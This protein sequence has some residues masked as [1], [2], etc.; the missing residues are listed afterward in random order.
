MKSLADGLPREIAEQIHPDW[1][2]NEAAY[3]AMREQLVARYQGQWIGF[4]DGAVVASGR[5]PVVVF[6]AAHQAAEHPFFVCVGREDEPCRI[7]R[8]TF[9]Y[10]TNYPGEALPVIEV[11]FRQAS[12]LPG[13]VLDRVV[14]DTGLRLSNADANLRLR[15]DQQVCRRSAKAA[16][17]SWA[18]TLFV[19]FVDRTVFAPDTGEAG[20]DERRVQA[21]IPPQVMARGSA[22]ARCN[23]PMLKPVG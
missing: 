11:E 12:G 21:I 10:D 9:A 22:N 17:A 2:K 23:T 8:S 6:H 1:R 4:A 19:P 18:T 16:K 20:L 7:R 3:W 13:I 15:P 14:A 5:S